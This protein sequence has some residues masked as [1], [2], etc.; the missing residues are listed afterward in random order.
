MNGVHADRDP[1]EQDFTTRGTPGRLGCPYAQTKSVGSPTNGRR[2]A[3]TPRSSQSRGSF[4]GRRSKRHS[5][6]DPI[7]AD[8]SCGQPI[9]AD[10]S[11]D[12][13]VPLC[14]IRFLDQHSPEELAKYF[15]N[16]KHELPR[17]HEV[18]IRRVQEDQGAI[19]QL[20]SKYTNMVNMVTELSKVHKPMLPDP[21]DIAVEDGDSTHDADEKVQ[22]WAKDVSPAIGTHISTSAEYGTSDRESRFDRPLNDVRLGESP[23]RPWGIPVPEGNLNGNSG[24]PKSDHTASP[25]D[26]IS[27]GPE[28]TLEKP[29]RCPFG[30]MMGENILP[31]HPLNESRPPPMRE[32]IT[33]PKEPEMHAEPFPATTSGPGPAR[34]QMVF[35]GPVFIGY[36]VDQALAFLNQAGASPWKG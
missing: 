13:S 32:P 18:C 11:I 17:S 33:M 21:D 24:S 20:D 30:Q 10:A 8:F 3:S 25:Q 27:G 6:H 34:P 15:E 22:N 2:G 4:S 7:R 26:P 16:H 35:N 5:F 9:S 29:K 12:G 23:S 1:L 19:Q 14:P 31:P 28:I 36:P